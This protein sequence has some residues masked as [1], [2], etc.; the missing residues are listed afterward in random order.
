MKRWNPSMMGRYLFGLACSL[1]PAVSSKYLQMAIPLLIAA[2]FHDIGI[3]LNFDS[4]DFY[5]NRI[6]KLYSKYYVIITHRCE[7]V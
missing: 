3:A 4:L 1:I 2:F 6:E 5:M 7:I